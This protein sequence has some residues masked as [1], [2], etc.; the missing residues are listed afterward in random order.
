MACFCRN[1][2]ALL[3]KFFLGLKEMS[4]ELTIVNVNAV[5]LHFSAREHTI[6]LQWR[7]LISKM[8][9]AVQTV[10]CSSLWCNGKTSWF[11]HWV[12]SFPVD[13][14]ATP[15]NLYLGGWNL[16]DVW[17]CTCVCVCVH[18]M[19]VS[20]CVIR[21]YSLDLDTGFSFCSYFC[22][23]SES[24]ICNLKKKPRDI[25][26]IILICSYTV[27]TTN[28]TVKLRILNNLFPDAGGNKVTLNNF[29]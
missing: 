1:K 6:F 13:S 11:K 17:L 14:G 8:V 7:N 23:M 24:R 29:S 28:P 15:V 4:T 22:D 18:R 19:C 12:G 2:E 16:S 9:S 5:I 26:Q 27:T 3:L 21:E 25:W 20:L 10:V